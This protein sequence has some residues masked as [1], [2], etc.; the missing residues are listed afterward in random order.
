MTFRRSFPASF[1][2]L[3]LAFAACAIVAAPVRAQLW[4]SP[5][6][7]VML[8]A[9]TPAQVRAR[10]RAHADSVRASAPIDAAE[11]WH[12]IGLSHFRGGAPDSAAL[13]YAAARTLRESPDDAYALAEALLARRAAG[14]ADSAARFVA[15][16]PPDDP[17]AATPTTRLWRAWALVRT[18]DA[19]GQ[20]AAVATAQRELRSPAIAPEL[21]VRWL[22]RF[23]GPFVDAGI[24]AGPMLAPL[25][26]ASRGRDA[27]IGRALRAAS[28]GWLGGAALDAVLAAAIAHADSLEAATPRAAGAKPLVV[29]A[30]DGFPLRAW[31]VRGPAAA[32]PLV[33]LVGEPAPDPWKAADSLL[34]HLRRAGFAVVLLDPRG[35]AGSVGAS[36]AYADDWTGRED[37]MAAAVAGDLRAA[38]RAAIASGAADPKRV[39]VGAVGPLAMSVALAARSDASVRALLFVDAALAPTD[40]GPFTAALAAAGTP[41]FFQTGAAAV[42][43][44][45][46]VDEVVARLP[47][48]QTRVAESGASGSGLALF[49]RGTTESA[50]FVDWIRNVWTTPRATPPA[51]PR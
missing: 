24:D 26:V 28:P 39:A 33:A 14:A 42:E 13:A 35:S 20:R 47:S 34:A 30:S 46:V 40:R 38:V 18:G 12:W 27:A 5:A 2:A 4:S 43:N 37:A 31:L 15:A 50:R 16:L 6:Q 25:A 51:R 44:N 41:A 9:P 22:R 32:S 49:R 7:R 23:A 10:L 17:D 48:R 21:R 29:R 45:W 8:G 1:R 19:A 36:C 11:A 3:A